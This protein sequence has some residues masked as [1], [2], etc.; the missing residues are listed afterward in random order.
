MSETS[1]NYWMRE[2]DRELELSYGVTSADLPDVLYRD[3]YE[4]GMDAGEASH[5]AVE[6]AFE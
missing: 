3:W 2:V 5:R 6:L 4:S 1:F